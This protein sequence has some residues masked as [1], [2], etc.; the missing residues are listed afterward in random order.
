MQNIIN[1]LHMYLQNIFFYSVLRIDSVNTALGPLDLVY[2]RFCYICSF[3]MENSLRHQL[4]HLQRIFASHF[5]TLVNNHTVFFFVLIN[6]FPTQ[7]T[8]TPQEV[9][10]LREPSGTSAVGSS[11]HGGEFKVLQN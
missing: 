8:L 11:F 2:P 6:T 10:K 4:C 9:K 3:S 1:T 7:Y 5:H